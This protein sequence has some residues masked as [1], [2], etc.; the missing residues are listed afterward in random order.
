MVSKI[1]AEGKTVDR[2]DFRWFL[3]F[4]VF[5]TCIFISIYCISYVNYGLYTYFEALRFLTESLKVLLTRPRI[6]AMYPAM[7]YLKKNKCK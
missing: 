2:E 1:R 7:E 4:Y 6:I 3:Q 5:I